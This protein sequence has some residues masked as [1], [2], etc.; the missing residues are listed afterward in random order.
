MENIEHSHIPKGRRELVKLVRETS[1]IIKVGDAAR[2]LDLSKLAAAKKLA[3]W[4]EQGWLR[5]VPD[6]YAEL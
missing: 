5:R 1:D 3:R 2:I 6:R 4:T